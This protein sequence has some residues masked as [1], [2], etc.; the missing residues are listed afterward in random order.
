[1]TPQAPIHIKGFTILLHI[2]VQTDIHS[3]CFFMADNEVI[4]SGRA[5]AIHNVSTP[6]ND[7]LTH[8][9][10]TMVC[11]PSKAIELPKNT[12]INA[13]ISHHHVTRGFISDHCAI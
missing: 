2:S 10:V 1:M 6:S 8:V 12:P 11:T 7:Q 5:E 13:T 4:N 9:T 3:A